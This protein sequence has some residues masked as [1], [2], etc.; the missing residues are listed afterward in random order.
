M[1]MESHI[2]YERSYHWALLLFFIVAINSAVIQADNIR[3]GQGTIDD[4]ARLDGRKIDS[5]VIENRNIYDLQNGL[6]NS[7]LYRLANKLHYV[8]REEIVERELLFATGD[9][10]DTELAEEV[11][12]NL[13]SRYSLN[14]AWIETELQ[15]SGGLIVRVVTVDE[16]SLV[17]GVEIKRDG[18]ETNVIVGFEERNFIGFNQFVSF[19]YSIYENEDNFIT[20]RF[21]DIRL[22]GKELSLQLDFSNEAIAEQKRIVIARPFYNLDQ[23]YSYSLTVR[24]S[25]G[26]LDVY[27]GSDIIAQSAVNRDEVT[28]VTD[29]RWGT[30]RRK[31]GV[32]LRYDYRYLTSTEKIIIDSSRISQIVFPVDSVYH[33]LGVGAKYTHSVFSKEKRINGFSYTEDFTFGSSIQLQIARAF[34]AELNNYVHDFFEVSA[35]LGRKVGHNLLLSSAFSS[36]WFR[37]DHRIRQLSVFSLRYYNNSLDFFTLAL[38]SRYVNDWRDSRTDALILGGINGLRGFD[39]FSFSGNRTF[40]TNLEGRLFTGLELISVGL[41]AVAFVDFGRAWSD[42]ESFTLGNLESSVGVGL[43]L[44]LEKLTRSELLRIDIAFAQDDNWHL[45]F[46]TGQYF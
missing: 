35:G 4:K 19:D 15:D 45:S 38:R 3:L 33:Q 42:G 1:R 25:G 37:G 21:R 28:I 31:T 39:R 13:R 2:T 9:E 34:T 20:A 23:K 32:S 10:F 16:W 29:Y 5:I 18:N 26:R 46:A 43:R 6:Y 36:I 7:F 27:D 22:A 12:R 24:N 8:T 30:Y 41:G 40:V 17:G 14:D 11:A 44:S